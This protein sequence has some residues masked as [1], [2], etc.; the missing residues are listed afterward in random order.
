MA[1]Y[2][3]VE[4]KRDVRCGNGCEAVFYK[5]PGP[6]RPFVIA[7]QNKECRHKG[8]VRDSDQDTAEIAWLCHREATGRA[9]ELG[10]AATSSEAV[11][12]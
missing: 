2:P 11:E 7:C 4:A 5:A 6:V 12:A 1:S 8:F 3:R 10:R 9:Y